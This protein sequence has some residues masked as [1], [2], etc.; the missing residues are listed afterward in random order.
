MGRWLARKLTQKG[1]HVVIIDRDKKRLKD[2]AEE[3]YETSAEPASVAGADALIFAVPIAGFEEAVKSVVAFVG[4]GQL[5]FD[6]TSVKSMPV[7]VMHKYLPGRSVLG[8]HPV[9]RITYDFS[10]PKSP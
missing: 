6:I 10:S 9:F 1:Q 3:G 7:E 4:P 5:F 8:T 2:A